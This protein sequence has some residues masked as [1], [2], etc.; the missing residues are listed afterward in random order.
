MHDI[1]KQPINNK[2]K[3]TK[4]YDTVNQAEYGVFKKRTPEIEEISTKL[5]EKSIDDVLKSRL[6][7]Q[8]KGLRP[9]T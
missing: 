8:E 3:A 2:F 5:I 7:L 1:V 4:S 9:R 6:R